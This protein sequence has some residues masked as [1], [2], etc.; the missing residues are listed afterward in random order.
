M[1]TRQTD[2]SE[3][4]AAVTRCVIHALASIIVTAI[5]ATTTKTGGFLL[6]GCIVF[7]V[8]NSG[9]AG[10]NLCVW[11]QAKRHIRAQQLIQEG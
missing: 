8:I 5:A 11:Q 6:A 4:Y 9:I 7:A 2:L 1:N 3:L 10:Y